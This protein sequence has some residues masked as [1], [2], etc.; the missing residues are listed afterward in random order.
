MVDGR[1]GLNGVVAQRRHRPG[2]KRPGQPERIA[3]RD[4]VL[5]DLQRVALA[6]LDDGIAGLGG[7]QLHQR[8]VEAAVALDDLAD[9]RGMRLDVLL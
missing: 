3:D 5:A 9:E 8:Q 7:G 1:L 2:R 4:H 6:Q